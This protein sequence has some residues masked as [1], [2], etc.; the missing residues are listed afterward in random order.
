[1][2]RSEAREWCM[3]LIYQLSIRNNFK[4]DEIERFIEYFDLPSSEVKYIR[5]NCKSIIDNLDNI[6]NIIKENLEGCWNYNRIAKIDL[7]SLRVAV[8]EIYYLYDIPE[9]VAI[10][11]AIE[12]ANKYSTDASYKFINGILG[13]IVRAKK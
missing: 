10:N 11:E 1:M 2:T 6:D 9:S 12:I 8:N 3:K 4:C 7:A 13:T 5:K